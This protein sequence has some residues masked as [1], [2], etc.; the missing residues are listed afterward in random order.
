VIAIRLRACGYIIYISYAAIA[1]AHTHTN[2][3]IFFGPELELSLCHR[4]PAQ[5]PGTDP[6]AQTPFEHEV[7][8]TL[9][10]LPWFEPIKTR[11]NNS[12]SSGS[13]HSPNPCDNMDVISDNISIR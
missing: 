11:F 8:I 1:L 12:S 6:G 10:I 7:T 9:I 2:T 4:L 5:T 13:K 3:H